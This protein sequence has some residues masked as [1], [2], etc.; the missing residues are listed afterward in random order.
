MNK[1]IKKKKFINKVNELIYQYKNI[2]EKDDFKYLMKLSYKKKDEFFNDLMAF[3]IW[4]S[5]EELSREEEEEYDGLLSRANYNFQVI[6]DLEVEKNIKD[7]YRNKNSI[8]NLN[9]YTYI[10]YIIYKHENDIHERNKK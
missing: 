7:R 1:R 9:R 10:A 2:L 4:I 6:E 8:F 3:F 5:Y